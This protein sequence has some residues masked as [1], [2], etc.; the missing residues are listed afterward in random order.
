MHNL[1]APLVI[2]GP[3]ANGAIKAYA[4]KRGPGPDF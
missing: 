2:T 3:I 4:K 1:I